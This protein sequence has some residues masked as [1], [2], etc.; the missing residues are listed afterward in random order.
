MSLKDD[1]INE[2]IE[3]EIEEA[4][5]QVKKIAKFRLNEIRNR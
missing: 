5:N 1:L 2:N 4:I 3:L